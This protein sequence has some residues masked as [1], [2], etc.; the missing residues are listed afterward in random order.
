MIPQSLN[1][2]FDNT[3]NL[4]ELFQTLKNNIIYII[5]ITNYLLQQVIVYKDHKHNYR[6]YAKIEFDY[7]IDSNITEEITILAQHPSS[8]FGR[9]RDFLN[10]LK[11]TF[12]G[13]VKCIHIFNTTAIVTNSI[14]NIKPEDLNQDIHNYI[15]DLYYEITIKWPIVI[16]CCGQHIFSRSALSKYIFRK[17]LLEFYTGFENIFLENISTKEYTINELKEYGL[18]KYP[19]C[20]TPKYI[21]NIFSLWQNERCKREEKI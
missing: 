9:S 20:I 2:T 14:D 17:Y 19:K 16:L 11:N 15:I 1:I 5:N 4:D 13:Y 8:I 10:P 7:D 6:L 12:N 18:I 3:T 21:K